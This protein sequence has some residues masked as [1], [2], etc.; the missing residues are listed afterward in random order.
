M[1]EGKNPE[2][3]SEPV[4]SLPKPEDVSKLIVEAMKR[5]EHLVKD[6]LK[7]GQSLVGTSNEDLRIRLR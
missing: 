1:S 7:L 6:A 5:S 4:P 3:P 2:L